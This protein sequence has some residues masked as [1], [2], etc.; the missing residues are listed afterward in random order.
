M[1]RF[2]AAAQRTLPGHAMGIQ[3]ITDGGLVQCTDRIKITHASHHVGDC[4]NTSSSLG[5]PALRRRL[6]GDVAGLGGA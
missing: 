5:S 6:A 3:K 4:A 2:T 1:W